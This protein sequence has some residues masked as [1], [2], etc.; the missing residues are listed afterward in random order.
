MLLLLI[1]SFLLVGNIIQNFHLTKSQ[2][3]SVEPWRGSNSSRWSTIPVTLKQDERPS[4]WLVYPKHNITLGN[5]SP[6]QPLSRLLAQ[7]TSP[8]QSVTINS[9]ETGVQHLH[10]VGDSAFAGARL[11]WLQSDCEKWLSNFQVKSLNMA[12]KK[13]ASLS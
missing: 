13:E 9:F 6:V 7:T 10:S 8:N 5:V 2:K 11:V 1:F 3:C 12:K 4:D